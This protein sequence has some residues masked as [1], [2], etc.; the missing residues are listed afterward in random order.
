MRAVTAD[1]LGLLLS[2]T[3]K[4]SLWASSLLLEIDERAQSRQADSVFGTLAGV[5]G[6]RPAEGGAGPAE[7]RIFCRACIFLLIFP[8]EMGRFLPL[9]E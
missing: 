5:A 8:D 7:A 2:Y 6:G 3:V 1:N 4:G 9:V